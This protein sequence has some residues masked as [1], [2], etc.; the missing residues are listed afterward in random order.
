MIEHAE[1]IGEI[2][3]APVTTEAVVAK[4]RQMLGE[5]NG[6]AVAPPPDS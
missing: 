2:L 3:V 1:G 4:V 5:S 6:D